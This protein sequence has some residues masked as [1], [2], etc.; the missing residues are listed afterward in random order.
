MEVVRDFQSAT[1]REWM[2]K[3]AKREYRVTCYWSIGSLRMEWLVEVYI[4]PPQ[5][6]SY[7]RR[8][9]GHDVIAAVKAHENSLPTDRN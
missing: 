3:A 4:S 8:V 9:N 6:T 1:R 5:S 2:V 7:W